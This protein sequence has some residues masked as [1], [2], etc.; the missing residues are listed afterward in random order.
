MNTNS[1]GQLGSLPHK[2]DDLL[3]NLTS[4]D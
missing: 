3:V 2:F 4:H 1:S